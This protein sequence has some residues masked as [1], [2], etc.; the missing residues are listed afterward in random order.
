[1]EVSVIIPTYNRI[2]TIGRALDSVLAQQGPVQEVLVVD[3]GSEDGTADFIAQHYPQVEVIRQTNTGVSAA[4]NRGLIKAKYEW[5]ALLD[6]DDEWLPNKLQKQRV[7][8]AE[9]NELICHTDEIWV[10]SGKRVN[11]MKKHKKPEGWIFKASLPLCCVSPSSVLVH[12][13]VFDR[14]GLFDESLPACEDY[15]LWLRIFSRYP[16]VLVP[17]LLLVKYGGHGDQLSRRYWGMDRFRVKA[18]CK[19]L[20]EGHLS[21]SDQKAALFTLSKKITVLLNGFAKRN[22]VE[23]VVRYESMLAHYLATYGD[24]T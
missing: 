5:I 12:R 6:S 1:M 22:K 24:R 14:V 16:V 9:T 10:R 21:V 13:S 20:D 3:D 11:P 23:E 15:D 2:G 19:V 18:L 8:L 7:V 4:R 17:E